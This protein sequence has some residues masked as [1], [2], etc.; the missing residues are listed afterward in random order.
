MVHDF[1]LD[2]VEPHFFK[3]V[4]PLKVF[5]VWFVSVSSILILFCRLCYALMF[6]NLIELD[7]ERLLLRRINRFTGVN[8]LKCF[9]LA[10]SRIR[11]RSIFFGWACF[12]N[13]LSNGDLMVM[14]GSTDFQSGD[15]RK[16]FFNSMQSFAD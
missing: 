4:S 1:L 12:L 15:E 9:Y 5:W 14:I 13:R 16:L 10:E 7:K 3:D 8:K 6:E 2:G 11:F